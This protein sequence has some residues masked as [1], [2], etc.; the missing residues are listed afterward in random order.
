MPGLRRTAAVVAAVTVAV[1]IAACGPERTAPT[2]DPVP[3]TSVDPLEAALATGLEIYSA[4][5]LTCHEAGQETELAPSM[6]ADLLDT[7]SSCADQNEFVALGADA[8]PS[9]TYGDNDSPFGDYELIM[10]GYRFAL[11]PNEIAAVNYWIRVEL[12]GV[13]AAE[14]FVACELETE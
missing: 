4:Q 8:W 10:T 11:E 9:E 13:D 12:A 2:I 5:C 6:R 3:S 14:A 1:S 7:F